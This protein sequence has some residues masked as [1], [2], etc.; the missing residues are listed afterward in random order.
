MGILC[1]HH[2]KK[3]LDKNKAL[4][5]NLFM[6]HWQYYKP[7]PSRNPN[8]TM[9]IELSDSLLSLC[10]LFFLCLPVRSPQS[11]KLSLQL[12][13]KKL[14]NLFFSPLSNI[15]PLLKI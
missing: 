7:V 5:V 8:F 9:Q 14:L 13:F 1:Q 4:N 2:L 12:F 6:W 10:A 15:D 3:L 11:S